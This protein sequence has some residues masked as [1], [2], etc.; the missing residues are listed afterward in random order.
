[1]TAGVTDQKPTTGRETTNEPGQ[2]SGNHQEDQG[3][4]IEEYKEALIIMSV[5]LVVVIAVA[6]GVTFYFIKCRGMRLVLVKL[7]LPIKPSP[8]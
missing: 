3:S 6:V 7:C 5:V 8:D 4:K 2:Q 1:M